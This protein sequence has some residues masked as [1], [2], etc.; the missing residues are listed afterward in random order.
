MVFGLSNA[1]NVE[2]PDT[3]FLHALIDEGVDTNG[4]SLIS[5]AEAE[6]ITTL[7]V[8]HRNISNLTGIEA[9][10]NLDTLDCSFNQLTSLD[11]PGC[12]K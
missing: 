11:Q 6:A 10:V 12:F 7:N 4:D 3:A 9:F 2:I 1:Q 8:T 5:Y